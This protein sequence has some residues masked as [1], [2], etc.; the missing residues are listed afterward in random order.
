MAT[1]RP[2][3]EMRGEVRAKERGVQ[4]RRTN[5]QRAGN[6]TNHG[7]SSGALLLPP[8]LP[9][10]HLF[11][12]PPPPPPPPPSRSPLTPHSS[13]YISVLFT[14][15][16]LITLFLTPTPPPHTH[17]P[18]VSSWPLPHE[19]CDRASCPTLSLA[20]TSLQF[21]FTAPA[22]GSFFFS[23]PPL[24]RHPHPPPSTK[25]SLSTVSLATQ[26]SLHS[27]LPSVGLLCCL[28]S[29]RRCTHH[30]SQCTNSQ[31]ADSVGS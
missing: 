7:C 12:T 2:P 14:S 19:S 10:L 24:P 23:S 25:H 15:L 29:L 13:L 18:L 28:Q 1:A 9:L 21:P 11:S 8:Y 20:T 31:G 5:R 30:P 3:A 26:P 22:L 16:F 4:Q 6:G 17:T 27:P